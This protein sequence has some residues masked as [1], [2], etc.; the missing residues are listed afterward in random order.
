[1]EFEYTCID[2]SGRE[3]KGALS[4]K[5]VQEVKS[6][7]KKMG[8]LVLALKEKVDKKATQSGRLYRTK[9]K[10]TDTDVYNLSRGMSVLLNAG[11]N[12]DKALELLIGSESNIELKG[13]LR[14]VLS[15]IVRG[16]SLSNAFEE[17][18]RF[19][20]LVTVMIKVGESTGDLKTAFDNI[21]QYMNFQIKFKNEIKNIMA[22]PLFLVSASVIILIAIFKFIIPRFFSIFGQSAS[23]LPLIS[24]ALYF[25]SN[26]INSAN[27]LVIIAV[28]GGLIIFSKWINY[29]I[30][31]KHLYIY[32]LYIPFFKNLVINLELSRFAYSMYSMLKSGVEFI[33]ALMLS[34]N[35]IQ[36]TKMRDEIER[37]IPQIK[38]GKGIA[39]A[40]SYVS[41]ISPMMLG[42]LKVGENSGN[43]KE[44]FFELYSIC[45]EKFKN[46]MKRTIVLLEPAIITVM[47]IFVGIIVLSLI[48][49]V[50]SVSNIKL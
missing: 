29:K 9:K 44:I 22:Y 18:T 46:S 43:L 19:N 21:S 48:L 17:T 6:K 12:L 47:G 31:F 20:P 3:F 10:I 26:I 25:T 7:L 40:F 30:I 42:M 38:E 49:T 33:R 36:V 24:R 15:D 2:T 50:M 13:I 28:I 8:F 16:E 41:F 27:V 1:M 39:D 23:S 4:A 45:D 32:L 14:Q 11:I 5:D 35:V 37:T 34:K